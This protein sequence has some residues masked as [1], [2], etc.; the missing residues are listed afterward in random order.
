[1][2]VTLYSIQGHAQEDVIYYPRLREQ[3]QPS[4]ISRIYPQYLMHKPDLS[5]GAMDIS[6]LL[7]TAE[8]PGFSIPF[9]L[10]YHGN[11]IKVTDPHF[12]LGYGW[13]LS[14]GLRITRNIIGKAD[15]QSTWEVRTNN[16]T[17]EYLWKLDSRDY[18]K[19]ASHD[20]FS[21]HLP[22]RNNTFLLEKDGTSW[23]V[24]A[25][26]SP[27]KITPVFDQY[28]NLTEFSVTDDRGI[29]YKFG[30][31]YIEK[32]TQVGYP[33]AWMLYEVD[34]AGGYFQ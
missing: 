14:P 25:A 30:G 11:G 19:D 3:I 17:Y 4:P 1:M 21:I 18:D 7:Y 12:P 29:I 32:D 6:I 23:K 16:F 22:D 34:I 15:E 5:T 13:M 28:K 10:K 27:L 24:L 8:T 31:Q 2:M 20:V 9:E 33:T 26:N